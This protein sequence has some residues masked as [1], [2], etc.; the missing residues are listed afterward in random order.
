[1]GDGW[2]LCVAFYYTSVLRSISFL[3]TERDTICAHANLF[4]KSK[5]AMIQFY[6]DD[7]D[8]SESKRERTICFSSSV[9][10]VGWRKQ[11]WCINRCVCC[12]DVYICM[13]GPSQSVVLLEEQVNTYLRYVSFFPSS[14]MKEIPNLAPEILETVF[15]SATAIVQNFLDF[16]NQWLVLL[17]GQE[18]FGRFQTLF[19]LLNGIL[20]YLEFVTVLHVVFVNSAAQLVH[21]TFVIVAIHASFFV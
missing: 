5:V 6:D 16:S 15:S 2:A 8:D 20:E 14:E 12:A 7:D 21:Q 3:H 18:M 11:K 10:K 17:Q 4:G 13:S 19:Q 9:L 1:M